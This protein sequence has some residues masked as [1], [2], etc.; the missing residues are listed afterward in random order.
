MAR[1]STHVLD[2]SRGMPAEGITVDLHVLRAAERCHLV[3][4]VT[5]AGGRTDRPLLEGDR[6]EVGIYELTFH[7]GEYF[8]GLGVPVTDPPFLDAV[9]IRF[10]IAEAVQNYH[11]PLLVTPYS[12]STYRGS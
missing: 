10:G 3:T 8:R 9:T 11:V 5:N 7:A 2:T 6:L 12:Y 1:L 4:L